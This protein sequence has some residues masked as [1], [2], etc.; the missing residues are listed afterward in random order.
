MGRLVALQ[1]SS[2][3]KVAGSDCAHAPWLASNIE[4]LFQELGSFPEVCQAPGV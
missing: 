2:K 3:L 4:D 1:G